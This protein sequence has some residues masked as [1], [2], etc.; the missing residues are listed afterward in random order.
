VIPEKIMS[1]KFLERLNIQILIRG[2]GRNIYTSNAF[3]SYELYQ[4]IPSKNFD[5]Y[6]PEKCVAPNR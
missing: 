6:H 2:F 4:Y 3:L 1:F 5:I